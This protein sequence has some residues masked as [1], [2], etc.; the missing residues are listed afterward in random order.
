MNIKLTLTA[1]HNDTDCGIR[2]A[3][4]ATIQDLHLLKT[5]NPNYPVKYSDITPFL[6]QN[7]DA[8]SRVLTQDVVEALAS[9]VV[10]SK[11]TQLYLQVSVWIHAPF[12]KEKF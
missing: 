7:C 5:N 10:G 11:A 2:N 6:R 1:G 12:R 8:T 4:I 9:S 3:L